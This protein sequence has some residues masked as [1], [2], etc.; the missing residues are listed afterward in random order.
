MPVAP[1]NLVLVVQVQLYWHALKLLR[2]EIRTTPTIVAQVAQ[3]QC[4][5]VVK[6]LLLLLQLGYA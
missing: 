5:S 4:Q 6:L 1:N 2:V 3:A